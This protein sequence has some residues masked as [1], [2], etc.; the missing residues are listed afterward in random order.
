MEVC[1][2]DKAMTDK[3]YTFENIR[4]LAITNS[5]D[6][7]QRIFVRRKEKKLYYRWV[8]YGYIEDYPND[9]AVEV[10]KNDET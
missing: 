7:P 2:K 4:N 6:L 8:G 9:E 10:Y 5:P 1:G 3:K